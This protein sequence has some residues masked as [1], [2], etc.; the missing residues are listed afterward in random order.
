[1]DFNDEG[2]KEAFGWTHEGMIYTKE[3][4][5]EFYNKLPKPNNLIRDWLHK[6][7]KGHCGR[8]LVNAK[9]GDF[10]P[11]IS[12]IINM[13]S[14]TTGNEDD[15]KKNSSGSST[16]STGEKGLDGVRSLVIAWLNSHPE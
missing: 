11:T 7:C 2:I 1:M 8:G 10:Y 12:K 15:S 6:D 5:Q 9:H 13:L 14:R 4:S 16:I 3:E